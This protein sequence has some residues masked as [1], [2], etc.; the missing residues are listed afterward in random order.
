M[1][2]LCLIPSPTP[3]S[4]PLEM[5]VLIGISDDSGLL[6]NR[7]ALSQRSSLASQQPGSQGSALPGLGPAL[8]RQRKA[9]LSLCLPESHTVLLI[10]LIISKKS[11]HK[12]STRASRRLVPSPKPL[13]PHLLCAQHLVIPLPWNIQTLE[14]VALMLVLPSARTQAVTKEEP[15]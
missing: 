15:N 8:A 9:A 10:T 6:K 11:V 13:R 7:T 2:L 1:K 14:R 12:A 4:L 5:L 3:I